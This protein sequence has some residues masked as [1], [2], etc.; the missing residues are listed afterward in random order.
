MAPQLREL[1]RCRPVAREAV[2][3]L[4]R[5]ATVA[6]AR[7][8]EV[9]S[10]GLVTCN[11]HA[12]VMSGVHGCNVRI[13]FSHSPPHIHARAAGPYAPGNSVI[14]W[15]KEDPAGCR[16]VR[17]H[18][19]ERKASRHASER[20]RQSR[21]GA[22]RGRRL[23]RW[24]FRPSGSR[25]AWRRSCPGTRLSLRA[26]LPAPGAHGGSAGDLATCQLRD[27][28]TQ[29]CAQQS[30]RCTRFSPTHRH[31]SGGSPIKWVRGK[32]I[33]RSTQLFSFR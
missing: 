9:A 13:R 7:D 4:S 18:H 15:L 33:S 27:A 24:D 2:G 20:E 23:T 28:E 22:T 14:S 1:V 3:E 17:P 32:L 10:Q 21:T 30:L 29:Y 16:R 11:L 6:A 19:L 5:A 25:P 26:R 12:E 31:R 8:R